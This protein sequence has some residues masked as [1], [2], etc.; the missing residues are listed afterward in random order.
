METINTGFLDRDIIKI[1]KTVHPNCK[2]SK[3]AKKY[4]FDLSMHIFEKIIEFNNDDVTTWPDALELEGHLA[5]R[6]LEEMKNVRERVF[7]KKKA[8]QAKSELVMSIRNTKTLL[9]VFESAHDHAIELTAL[10]E[11]L[12][13]EIFIP[14]G[15]KAI[16][17][18]K[19]VISADHIK[20]AISEDEELLK[21]YPQ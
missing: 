11:Y 18:K 15:K 8:I 6:A 9:T 2:I 12:L 3:L 21:F 19:V 10:I 5:D 13:T 17:D 14:A 1:M 20:E 7:K 16:A 4:M